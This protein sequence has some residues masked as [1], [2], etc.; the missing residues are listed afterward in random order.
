MSVAKIIKAFEHE[1]YEKFTRLVYAAH[2]LFLF[3]KL[4]VDIWL[5]FIVFQT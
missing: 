3:S 4:V 5:R 1:P 2:S